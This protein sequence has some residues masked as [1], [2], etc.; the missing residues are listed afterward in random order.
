MAADEL[1]G[2][3][4]FCKFGSVQSGTDCKCWREWPKLEKSN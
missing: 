4:A 1:C 3:T 2:G